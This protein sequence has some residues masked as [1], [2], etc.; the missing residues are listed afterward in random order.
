M[1]TTPETNGK[2]V[3]FEELMECVVYVDCKVNDLYLLNLDGK[4]HKFKNTEDIVPFVEKEL[5]YKVIF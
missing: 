2:H 4:T 1:K 3:H 5:S